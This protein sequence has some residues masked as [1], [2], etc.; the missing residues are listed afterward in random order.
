MLNVKNIANVASDRE[1]ALRQEQFAGLNMFVDESLMSIE[2]SP[3][4]QNVIF[5]GGAIKRIEGFGQTVWN[6]DGTSVPLRQIPESVIEL[7]EYQSREGVE[8]G[9]KNLYF[10]ASDGNLYGF[11]LSASSGKVEA[12]LMENSDL[13]AQPITYFTQYKTETANCALLGGPLCRPHVFTEGG[14]VK[15]ISGK[16]KPYMSKTAM[17][18]G[19]MF[20]IGD[21]AYPQRLWFSALNEP[22]NFEIGEEAGGYV[23]INDFIGDTIDVVSFFD[24]LYVFCRYGIVAVNALSTQREFSV[25]N[26]YYTDSEIIK[27]S[28]CICGSTVLFATRRGIYALSGSSVS[29]LSNKIKN[30]FVENP[31]LCR[32]ESSAYFNGSYYLSF[33]KNG[34]ENGILIYSTVQH[35]FV[36]RTQ[37]DVQSMVVAR[38]N[39]HEKLLV[40]LTD[41]LII[42]E[43]GAG[44]RATTSGVIDSLWRSPYNHWGIANG[45]KRIKEIHFTASGDGEIQFTVIADGAEE[46]RT[47]ELQ[48][49]P[50]V[51]RLPFDIAG[52]LVG[53]EIRNSYGSNFRVSP[54]TIIYTLERKAVR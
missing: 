25:E 22:W 45:Q 5:D 37:A 26:I 41:A 15:A 44:D 47:V 52:D 20:G 21:P 27:G 51:F 38:D 6:W 53:L 49:E 32:K 2:E 9:Y 12:V 18:Y 46:S 40:A 50:R 24:T 48:Q 34:G 28:V 33:H 30:F 8:K 16:N 17:H 35:D 54:V 36:I 10:S 11:E 42:L 39:V 31:P 14:G 19:R 3:C 43:W 13:T 1:Y 23:E 4:A 7:F 29:C